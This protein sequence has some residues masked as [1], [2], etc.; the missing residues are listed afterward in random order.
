[1]IKRIEKAKISELKPLFSECKYDRVLIDSVLEGN[2]GEAHAIVSEGKIETVRFDSGAFTI[3]AGD[4]YLEEVDDLI[5]L[6]S[7]EVVTP[8]DKVWRDVLSH[9]FEEKMSR[10]QFVKFE[11]SDVSEKHLD[12]YVKKLNPAYELNT[13]SRDLMVRAI[14][15]LD[16][17][18]LM[19]N[20]SSLEDF[21]KRGMG[22]FITFGGKVVSAATSVARSSKAIDIEI[23]TH[24]DHMHKGL[25]SAVG[26]KLTL[27]CISKGVKPVWLAAT[28]ASE[29][30][31]LKLG[32]KRVEAY[33]TYIIESNLLGE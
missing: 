28:K 17:P 1:M 26:A 8:Q 3:L 7:V 24:P 18:N 21:S 13:F 10:I 9:K 19:E 12:E 29:N 27:K 31:A 20:F 22:F 25:A 33:E 6:K 4:P 16:N 30:L 14:D 23:E 5:A 15:D 11:A 2:G 32:Y